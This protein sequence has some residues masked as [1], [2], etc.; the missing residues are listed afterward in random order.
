MRKYILGYMQGYASVSCKYTYLC[1]TL[2]ILQE[3]KPQEMGRPLRKMGYPFHRSQGLGL[4]KGA[5]SKEK[6]LS[7]PLYWSFSAPFPNNAD[8][9]RRNAHL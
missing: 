8:V 3:D 5:I 9:F 4:Q 6:T 2:E 7:L 1:R